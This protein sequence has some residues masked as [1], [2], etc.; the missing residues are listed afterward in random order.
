MAL[1]LDE[2]PDDVESLKAL[3]LA[4]D[5]KNVGLAA[6]AIGCSTSKRF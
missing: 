2:L 4:A 3:I 6:E 1:S 5:V